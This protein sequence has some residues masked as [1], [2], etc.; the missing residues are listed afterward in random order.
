MGSN[1]SQT[2]TI[3]LIVYNS[4]VATNTAETIHCGQTYMDL[5]RLL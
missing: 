3:Y 5:T 4:N 2:A 1:C